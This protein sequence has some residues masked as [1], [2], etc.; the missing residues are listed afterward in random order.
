MLNLILGPA[1]CGKSSR[2]L[3]R[4]VKNAG[5]GTAGQLLLVPEYFSHETER[6][7]AAAGGPSICRYAE[8]LSFSR[9]ATRVFSSEGGLC[10]QTLDSGGRLLAMAQALETVRSR[11]KL[12]GAASTRP[13]FYVELLSAVD[14]FKSYAVTAAQLREAAQSAGFASEGMLAVKLEDLSLILESY[15]AVCANGKADPRDRLSLLADQ[16]TS[17]SW[18]A[19]RTVFV[20]GFTGFT[21]LELHVLEALLAKCENMTL[22]LTCDGLLEGQFIYDPVRKTAADMQ[23]M[24][25]RIGIQTKVEYMP[26]SP[27]MSPAIRYLNE[28]L[29]RSDQVPY[30]EPASEIRLLKADSL[31]EE[32]RIAVLRILQLVHSGAHYGDIAVAVTDRSS[33]GPVLQGLCEQYQIPLYMSG[34][35]DILQKPVIT[36]LTAALSAASGGMETEDVLRYLK[37]GLSPIP[38]DTCDCLE[39]Y[40]LVWNLRGSRWDT[41]FTA[42]PDG[43]GKEINE[44][45]QSALEKLN[46]GREAGIVPLLHLQTALRGAA[47]TDDM[48]LALYAFIE[49]IHLESRLEQQAGELLEAGRTQESA[50]CVQ[51]YSILTTALEQCYSVLGKTKQEPAA[52]CRLFE[53]QLSQYDVGTIPVTLDAVLCGSV[54]SLRSRAPTHLLVLGAC[55]ELFPAGTP[56]SG[57]L[58]EADRTYLEDYGIRLAADQQDGLYLELASILNLLSSP[59]QSLQLSCQA[60]STPSFLFERLCSLFPAS[61]TAENSWKLEL[62]RE[63]TAAALLIRKQQ[64]DTG[65]AALENRLREIP[66]VAE[67]ADRL[68]SRAAHQ[69]GNLSPELVDALWKT[70]VRLSASR[71]ETCAACRQKFFLNYGLKAGAYEKAVFASPEFGT[72]VHYVL[73]N[74]VSRIEQEGGFAD[75]TDAQI[76][77][78]AEQYIRQYTDEEMHGLQ[79]QGQRFIWLY[80]HSLEEV[81]RVVLNLA[82]ELKVSDFKATSFELYFGETADKAPYEVKSDAGTG[83]ITGFVDRVDIWENDGVKYYRIIDYKTGKTFFDF[84]SIYY[85][86]GLQMLIY[87]F[88]L[89]G[90]EKE[91]DSAVPAGVM[92]MPARNTIPASPVRL[93]AAAAKEKH[94]E[95]LR[96]SGILLDDELVLQAMEH[97]EEGHNTVFLPCKIDKNGYQKTYLMNREQRLLL[98]KHVDRKLQEL[99]EQIAT[100]QVSPNPYYKSSGT[101]CDVCDYAAV[102]H[103]DDSCRRYFAAKKHE[104]FWKALEKLEGGNG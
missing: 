2:I 93:D 87:L 80:N 74:T 39:N 16:I 38:Q 23:Q 1:G 62:Y 86:I 15:D 27:K 35:S 49:E 9:L 59:Q 96:R 37:T 56:F 63:D 47:H 25:A 79:G 77:A 94:A 92:Y 66:A 12:Y 81:R 13:A 55:D 84:T 104:E 46:A 32:C 33:Y 58:S 101:P 70:P 64:E 73:E 29:F 90:G 36:C 99:L 22:A 19:G 7:L 4:I 68:Q 50:E 83:K 41:P 11:L 89:Q 69:P 103:P 21:R 88:A 42:H 26:A 72:F 78:V 17:G 91:T 82:A 44:Q 67:Q 40:A 53:L 34:S 43:F 18:A 6:R 30:P 52:F 65:H 54:E 3:D 8:V 51:L 97:V 57:V 98:R 95:E 31:R 10:R 100:G 75:K 61:V 71:L 102:C 5:N 20:D 60:E 14:E 28:H 76:A 48:V 24:A 85:G 45:A